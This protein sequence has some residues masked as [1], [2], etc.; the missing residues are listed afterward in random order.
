MLAATKSCA[1]L[2]EPVEP[3]RYRSIAALALASGLTQSLA[4]VIQCG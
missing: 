3:F 1:I 2:T 4:P